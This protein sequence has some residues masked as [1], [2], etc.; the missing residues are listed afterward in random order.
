M[1]KK[2]HTKDGVRTRKKH[3]IWTFDENILD[4]STRKV[5]RP[6]IED[7]EQLED[8]EVA[9]KNVLVED[10]MIAS[11][12]RRSATK[13]EAPSALLEERVPGGVPRSVHDGDLCTG[14]FVAHNTDT[15]LRLLGQSGSSDDPEEL[16]THSCAPWFRILPI[17]LPSFH[18]LQPAYHD[19]TEVEFFSCTH[20]RWLLARVTLEV[21]CGGMNGDRSQLAIVYNIRV[22]LT[23][24]LRQ[25]TELHLLRKP[26][27]A[28]ERVEVGD[29]SRRPWV[30]GRI[31]KVLRWPMDRHFEVHL[32]DSAAPDRRRIVPGHWVRRHFPLGAVVLAYRGHERGWEQGVVETPASLE[33]PEQ[34]SSESALAGRVVI[35]LQE[36]TR[37]QPRR[38]THELLI[39]FS[40]RCSDPDA[41]WVQAHLV[42][43]NTSVDTSGGYEL[44]CVTVEV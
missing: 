29:W 36:K 1:K 39:R 27:L 19:G 31:T 32:D 11:D 22:G 7:V 9:F 5:R 24:Q 37:I 38:G 10:T 44:H 23:G 18:W 15:R 12:L 30:T 43:P 42:K 20:R 40:A 34:P 28:D 33:P 2:W 8:R 3:V 17:G 14:L 21:L 16:L 13:T 6:T 4:E 41:E 35:D 26:L 25:D